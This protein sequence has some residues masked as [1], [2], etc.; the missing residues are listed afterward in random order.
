MRLLFIYAFTNIQVPLFLFWCIYIV[1]IFVNLYSNLANTFFLELFSYFA[2]IRDP[3]DLKKHISY[4]HATKNY[5]CDLCEKAC[6]QKGNLM[7]HIENIHFPNSFVHLC[8]YCGAEF[9]KKNLLYQH[10]SYSHRS[11]KPDFSETAQMHWL[12]QLPFYL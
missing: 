8:R 4:N 10:V 9:S 6:L 2:G 12:H 5:H 7:K 11:R 3:D 1:N